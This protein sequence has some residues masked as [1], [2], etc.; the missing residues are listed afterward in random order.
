MAAN[1]QI[2]ATC[3]HCYVRL[4]KGGEL[5]RDGYCYANPPA[6]GGMYPKIK[7]VSQGC[8]HYEAKK[9]GEKNILKHEE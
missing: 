2:C 1:K 5:P 8:R 7:L 9:P 3:K 6:I 4:R